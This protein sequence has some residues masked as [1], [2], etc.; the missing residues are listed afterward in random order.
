M[1]R[2]GRYV[3]GATG[4]FDEFHSRVK[5]TGLRIEEPDSR[6]GA[7]GGAGR[8]RKQYR[9]QT[10]HQLSMVVRCHVRMPSMERESDAAAPCA[11]V[12]PNS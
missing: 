9:A 7:P 8:E 4:T 10:Q 1:Q 5:R 2:V 12:F 3:D 11:G 6:A